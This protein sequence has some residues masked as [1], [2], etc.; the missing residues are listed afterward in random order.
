MGNHIPAAHRPLPL[1]YQCGVFCVFGCRCSRV[2]EG[3]RHNIT[4]F[5]YTTTTTLHKHIPPLNHIA[6][7]TTTHSPR[8]IIGGLLGDWAAYRS[9]KY[10]RIAVAQTSVTLGIP[11]TVVALRGMPLNGSMGSVV[12]YAL[13]MLVMGLCITWYDAGGEGLC[14]S[15]YAVKTICCENHML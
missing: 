6:P 13:L 2:C 8:S 14:G 3:D 9:P 5:C 11:L 10:G 7:S 12:A 1:A 15:Y 4:T